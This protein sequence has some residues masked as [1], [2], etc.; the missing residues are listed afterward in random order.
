[1]YNKLIIF[2]FM[3]VLVWGCMTPA[4]LAQHK[5]D[6]AKAKLDK[7]LLEFPELLKKNDTTLVKFDTVTMSKEIIRF[8]TV[9]RD[10]GISIDTIVEISNFDSVFT[11]FSKEM[12][13][14]IEKMGG[15]L[16]RARGIIKPYYITEIDTF[17]ITDTIFIKTVETNTIQTIDNK[18][19]FW[20]NLWFQ[21]KGWIWLILIIIAILVILRVIFKFV[22]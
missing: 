10:G 21:V 15:E 4:E 1:M 20:W 3:L 13:I 8:D 5:T 19:S 9:Y 17:N 18:P 7:L 6:R 14:R 22:G 12:E 16:V 2:A 11:V